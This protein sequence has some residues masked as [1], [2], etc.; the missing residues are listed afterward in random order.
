MLHQVTNSLLY[1]KKTL[2]S[3]VDCFSCKIHSSHHSQT[4]PNTP[5]DWHI[6]YSIISYTR[7]EPC[8]VSDGRRLVKGSCPNAQVSIGDLLAVGASAPSH[9]VVVTTWSRQPEQPSSVASFAAAGLPRRGAGP[10]EGLSAEGLRS[11]DPFAA[12]RMPPG[13]GEPTQ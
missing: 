1:K 9:A 4:F 10:L 7:T 12:C 6:R 13:L 2:T 5:W 11:H 3:G 8:Q